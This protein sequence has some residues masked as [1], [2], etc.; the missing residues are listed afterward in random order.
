MQPELGDH[1]SHETTKNLFDLNLPPE[2]QP[3]SESLNSPPRQP[4]SSLDGIILVD[5]RRRKGDKLGGEVHLAQ[6]ASFES[7]LSVYANH[8]G[9]T[10]P[11]RL[12]SSIGSSSAGSGKRAASDLDQYSDRGKISGNNHQVKPLNEEEIR[13]LPSLFDVMKC[14]FIYLLF[15]LPISAF[16]SAAM[17]SE[18]GKDVLHETT[19]NL[20]DLNLPP[21]Q[22]PWS[23]S[24]NSPRRQRSLDA[25]VF[26]DPHRPREEKLGGEVHRLLK[27]ASVESGWSPYANHVGQDRPLAQQLVSSISS[28]SSGTGKRKASDWGQNSESEK[29]N[30]QANSHSDNSAC[31]IEEDLSIKDLVE[32]SNSFHSNAKAIYHKSDGHVSPATNHHQPLNVVK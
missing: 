23:E 13:S 14:T 30:H 27:L 21:E 6:P 2:Q 31:E 3:W 17:Q 5:S 28:A 4:A 25:T 19:K 9:E 26:A 7:G 1:V 29:S 24:L 18:L 8:V 22:Q 10:P 15:H 12:F 32:G 11:Q 16:L 20:F